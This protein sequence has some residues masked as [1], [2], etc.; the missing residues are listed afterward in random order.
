MSSQADFNLESL[1]NLDGADDVSSNKLHSSSSSY[2]YSSII[3]LLY[4]K[5]LRQANDSFFVEQARKT[6][7]FFP[8]S[9]WYAYNLNND[10]E[11]EDYKSIDQKK[12]QM[13]D[14]DQSSS[15]KNEL[16]I[17]LDPYH[18]IDYFASQGIKLSQIDDKDEFGKKVKSFTAWLKTMKRLQPDHDTKSNKEDDSQPDFTGSD[19]TEAETIVTEAMADV[20]IKQGLTDKA[21]EIYHKLSLQNPNNSHIFADKISVLKE[22]RQ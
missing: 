11:F 8:F 14:D 10:F 15:A 2:P 9:P 18:T 20:Y 16:S 17:P 13:H 1:L 22:K 19:T 12:G 3:Q 21:I 7:L 6:S 4:A 5:Q